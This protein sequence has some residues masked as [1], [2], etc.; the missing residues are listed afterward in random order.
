MPRR[1]DRLHENFGR[2]LAE[3][4]LHSTLGQ[5]M[6]RQRAELEALFRE[7]K[8]DW[9]KIAEVFGNAGLRDENDRKPTAESAERA[10]RMVQ[11]RALADRRA[12]ELAELPLA[13]RR[14]VQLA[15]L[16]ERLGQAERQ[17][18]PAAGRP[19]AR[20]VRAFL[21]ERGSR[22]GRHSSR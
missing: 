5:W 2:A 4:P 1:P 20:A 22:P 13:D 8:P 9:T 3:A 7:G 16:R 17:A 14:A 18:R 21:N 12:A 11:A 6:I 15:E 19:V 10:W